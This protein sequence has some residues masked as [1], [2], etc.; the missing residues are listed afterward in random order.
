M[1][2]I[3]THKYIHAY[4]HIYS[5]RQHTHIPVA[6]PKPVSHTEGYIQAIK[7]QPSN[8]LFG[9]NSNNVIIII[10]IIIIDNSHLFFTRKGVKVKVKVILQGLFSTAA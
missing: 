9:S 1:Y 7:S 4:I 6:N 3:H 8:T 2:I 10:I 5:T